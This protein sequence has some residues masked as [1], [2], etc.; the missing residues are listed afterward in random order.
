MLVSRD[1]TAM[2]TAKTVSI[3][4]MKKIQKLCLASTVLGLREATHSVWKE[5]NQPILAPVL[6][7]VVVVFK[8]ESWQQCNVNCQNSEHLIQEEFPHTN[9]LLLCLTS[10][11]LGLR[12]ATHSGRRV[13]PTYSY[14][15]VVGFKKK[16]TPESC[17][18]SATLTPSL[19]PPVKFLGWLTPLLLG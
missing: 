14:S 19:P 8:P 3:I 13:K 15:I 18:N 5:L 2:L 6:V 7:F 9:P 17:D 11:V 16:I 4:F 10:T 12:Y 1:N